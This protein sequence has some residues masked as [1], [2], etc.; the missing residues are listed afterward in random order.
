MKVCRE[1][2]TT[3]FSWLVRSRRKGL[4]PEVFLAVL[5]VAFAFLG[6]SNETSYHTISGP[7]HLNSVER[8]KNPKQAEG[9]QDLPVYN[10]DE[11]QGLPASQ[12]MAKINRFLDLLPPDS[13]ESERILFLSLASEVSEEDIVAILQSETMKD[14]MRNSPGRCDENLTGLSLT[15][16]NDEEVK[17][18]KELNDKYYTYG[19]GFVIFMAAWT[20]WMGV[21]TG[22]KIR[23][24]LRT[25]GRVT[26]SWMGIA[27]WSLATAAYG[28]AGVTHLH[29]QRKDDRTESDYD[30]AFLLSGIGT[31]LYGLGKIDTLYGRMSAFNSRVSN[32]AVSK[33]DPLP[34]GRGL[35]SGNFPDQGRTVT[36]VSPEP[37][38]RV[39]LDDSFYQNDQFKMGVGSV[40]AFTAIVWGTVTII[41]SSL[42]IHSKSVN[43]SKIHLTGSNPNISPGQASMSVLK[44]LACLVEEASGVP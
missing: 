4:D 43:K 30:V 25:P 17:K 29:A 39:T 23:K 19:F 6:C 11:E 20:A 26:G 24:M 28:A 21:D 44:E 36:S 9:L 2:A 34:S 12:I 18:L 27:F 14:I 8:V 38:K 16:K 42:D 40:L 3:F 33:I 35:N 13:S 7:D 41:D 37:S 31:V 5:W 15:N 32:A 1:I 10:H 22:M